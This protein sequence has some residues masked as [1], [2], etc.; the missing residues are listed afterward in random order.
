M[1]DTASAHAAALAVAAAVAVAVAVAAAGG[2][3]GPGAL[4][5][6]ENGMTHLCYS[7]VG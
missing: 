5:H 3:W 4:A 2:S 1:Y 7:N 6:C